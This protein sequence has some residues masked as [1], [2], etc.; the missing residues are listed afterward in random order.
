VNTQASPPLGIVELGEACALMRARSLDLFE[1]LGAL[2]TT[3]SDPALQRTFAA[4]SHR[5][6]W[7]AEL[8]AARCPTIPGV[9]LDALTARHRGIRLADGP[10]A[11]AYRAILG[12]LI[13]ELEALDWRVDPELDPGTDRV[14]ALVGADLADL[15]DRL[16][17]EPG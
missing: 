4:A 2:V 11:A 5:H 6:A 12:E 16:P 15:R 7:H 17:R 13:V 10:P 1:Q 9:D 3:T 14:V 8:W